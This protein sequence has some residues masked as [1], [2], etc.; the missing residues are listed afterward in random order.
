MWNDQRV[1]TCSDL[2]Q[3]LNWLRDSSQF[4]E[5]VLY[6]VPSS[7]REISFGAP[8]LRL[9]DE[10]PPTTEEHV[11]AILQQRILDS[12]LPPGQRIDLDALGRELAV[13]RTPLRTALLRLE[14]EGLVAVYPHRGAVVTEISLED[15]EQI[16]AVRLHL[17]TMASQ[18]A[19]PRLSNADLARMR[20]IHDVMVA[21]VD[22]ASLAT[23]IQYDR[24]FHLTLYRAAN[25][26][27]LA[28]TI[29]DLRKGSLRFLSTY[30]SAAWLAQAV[31]EHDE[32]LAAATSH[33]AERVADLIRQ[34]LI[35]T[36]DEI[37][38][39]LARRVA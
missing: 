17:E 36:R 2:R 28:D 5:N 31:A 21:S 18:L 4:G 22:T 6:S 30:A 15:L 10:R 1:V 13:S 3:K 34:S 32:V 19:T 16:Y 33:D 8:S 9:L 24:V 35:R 27:F 7:R 26:K 29:D 23:F 12:V 25:N 14:S 38:T 11:Y 37:A 20:G 39:A